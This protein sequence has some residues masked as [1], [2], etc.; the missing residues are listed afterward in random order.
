MKKRVLVFAFHDRHNFIDIHV[1]KYLEKIRSSF[2]KIIF[3]QITIT[4]TNYE[5]YIPHPAPEQQLLL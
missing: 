4:A 1:I 5:A 2:E 3:V